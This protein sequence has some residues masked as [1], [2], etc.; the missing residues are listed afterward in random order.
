M[1]LDDRIVGTTVDSALAGRTDKG[2][3]RQPAGPDGELFLLDD[4]PACGG[5]ES[6]AGGYI[7]LELYQRHARHIGRAGDEIEAAEPFL[8][9]HDKGKVIGHDPSEIAMAN[10]VLDLREALPA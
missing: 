4:M 5:K 10:R 1:K 2:L 9:L 6:H 3:Y 7:D 8:F